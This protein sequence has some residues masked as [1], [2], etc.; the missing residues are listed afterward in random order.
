MCSAIPVAMRR[1]FANSCPHRAE[2]AT[3][4]NN[5]GEVAMSGD[6]RSRQQF[7]V[8]VGS[9]LHRQRA[10]RRKFSPGAVLRSSPAD[11]TGFVR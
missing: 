1:K 8:S 10:E 11:E 4:I 3:P 7:R 5:L 2:I 9:A 6:E